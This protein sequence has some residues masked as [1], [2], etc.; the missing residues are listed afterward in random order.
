MAEI[1]SGG[2]LGSLKNDKKVVT[3]NVYCENEKSISLN[4]NESSLSYLTIEEAIVLRNE[5]NNALKKAIGV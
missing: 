3:I 1:K 2:Q 5:I 4:I